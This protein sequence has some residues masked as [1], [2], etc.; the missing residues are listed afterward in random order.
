MLAADTNNAA[1]SMP[2]M[3]N[4]HVLGVQP[5]DWSTSHLSIVVV[6]ASG[7]TF[8]CQQ[9]ACLHS[10]TAWIDQA[11]QTWL[12]LEALGL[13]QQHQAGP[14]PI[15]LLAEASALLSTPHAWC[16]QRTLTSSC[17]AAAGDLAKKKIYPAL[18]ALFYEGMLPKDF[19]IYGYARSQM[20]DDVFRESIMAMLPCRL[21]DAEDCSKKMDAFMSRCSLTAPELSGCET[22]AGRT[23]HCGHT[24][25]DICPVPAPYACRA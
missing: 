7:T 11:C 17:Y 21:S 6:G 9:Q 8:Q 4:M 25:Q 16:C 10:P 12:Q 14:V 3:Q 22:Q 18:F 2:S 5:E 24:A 23:K 15:T 19:M 1:T 13:P 20:T